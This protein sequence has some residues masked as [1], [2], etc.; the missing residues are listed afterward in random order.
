MEKINFNNTDPFLKE[1]GIKMEPKMTKL[2]AKKIEGAT[3]EYGKGVKAEP[4][5]GKWDN[6][7]KVLYNTKKISK[8]IMIDCS[9]LSEDDLNK[10]AKKFVD[11]AEKMQLIIEDPIKKI[12]Y[13]RNFHNDFKK[14]IIDNIK[15]ENEENE[16]VEF[17]MIINS[18]KDSQNYNILK[19]IGDI[20][21]GLI[22]QCIDQSAIIKSNK[23]TKQ[24]EFNPNIDQLCS[25]ICLKVNCKL[26]G[27]NFK[28]S[29]QDQ[30][31]E[32]KFKK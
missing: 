6:I 18:R 22:T 29:T 16:N 10:F 1:Y 27:T 25:N 31:L 2:T 32:K 23:K 24:K 19:E 21:C 30:K 15:I 14:F 3:L 13:N 5:C 8:W 12:K 28:I 26:G 4:N 17:L 7:G 9:N 20:E 11:N